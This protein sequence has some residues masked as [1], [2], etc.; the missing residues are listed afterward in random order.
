MVKDPPVSAI[1]IDILAMRPWDMQFWQGGEGMISDVFEASFIR[2]A[3]L[4]VYI[5]L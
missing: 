2:R 1:A 5:L 4:Y 3:I